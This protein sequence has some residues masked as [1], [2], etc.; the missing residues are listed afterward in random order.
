[1]LRSIN[2]KKYWNIDNPTQLQ[3]YTTGAVKGGVTVCGILLSLQTAQRETEETKGERNATA[4][5]TS[6]CRYTYFNQPG[7]ILFTSLKTL[8]DYVST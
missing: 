1:M 4:T 3:Q 6:G 5:T 2:S 8:I 7:K